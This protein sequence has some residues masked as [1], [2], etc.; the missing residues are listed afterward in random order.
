MEIAVLVVLFLLA[1]GFYYSL[2]KSLNKNEQN[3]IEKLFN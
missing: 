1:A 3:E 2:L